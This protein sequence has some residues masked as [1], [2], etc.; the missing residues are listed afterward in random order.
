MKFNKILSDLLYFNPVYASHLS[1]KWLISWAP[2]TTLCHPPPPHTH[3]LCMS[4]LRLPWTMISTVRCVSPPALLA[5]QDNWPL[6]ALVALL[7]IDTIDT[8]FSTSPIPVLPTVRFCGIESVT[9]LNDQVI[10]GRGYPSTEQVNMAVSLILTRSDDPGFRSVTVA[11]TAAQIFKTCVDMS[12]TD[13]P[14][15]WTKQ[16]L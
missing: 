10:F 13:K 8:S 6:C 14:A 1:I 2:P 7:V 5:A 16:A 15:P 11:C 9:P 4:L 12:V 3:T